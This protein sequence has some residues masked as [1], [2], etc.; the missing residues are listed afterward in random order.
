TGATQELTKDQL[1]AEFPG[2]ETSDILEAAVAGFYEVAIGSSVAYVSKDGRYI[3][4][5]DLFDLTEN[6][7]LTERRRS[8]ARVDMLATVDSETMIVFSP[9]PDEVKHTITIFTDIDCGYCRQFHREIET[10]NALGVAVNYLFYPRTGPETESWFKADKV[11]CAEN[12]NVA[13]TDA[14]LAGQVPEDECES[15]P[16]ESHWDLGNLVGVRGTPTI[17]AANG[18]HI[19]GYLTPDQLLELLEGIEQ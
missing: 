11:W 4:Q 1:A 9:P 2:I 13:L 12:R 18:E 5:G 10:V 14:K 17:Y 3:L 6:T 15:T 16:V 7:N 8:S 19:G